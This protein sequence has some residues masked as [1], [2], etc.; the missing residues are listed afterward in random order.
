MALGPVF[1]GLLQKL[2]ATM[3]APNFTSFTSFAHGL[4]FCQPADDHP[5]DPLGR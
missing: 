5:H 4:G 3:T 2:S 1:V